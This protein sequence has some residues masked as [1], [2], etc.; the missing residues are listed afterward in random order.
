VAKKIPST[1]DDLFRAEMAADGVKPI[2]ADTR[3][4][5]SKPKPKPIATHRDRDEANV[6]LELL[7]D[8]SGW[9]ADIDTGDLIQFIRQGLPGD[10]LRK[11]KRGHWAVQATL[12]LHG[13]TTAGAR[14]G[15]AKFLAFARHGGARCVRIVHGKGYRSEG[16][17]P[18]I[19]NKVRL[20][21]SQREEVL[22]FCDAPPA[23]G[24]SGAVVVLL[25]SS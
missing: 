9:D 8:T 25:R 10:I 2:K 1:E 19:R 15:L 12:D 20:S 3:A 13:L 11:L 4:E 17:I 16:G 22:A 14:T 21:L 18:L 5:L 6:P 7:K 23:D 24:G